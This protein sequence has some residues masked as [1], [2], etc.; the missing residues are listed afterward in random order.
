MSLDS[1]FGAH[2]FGFDWA[3]A[4]WVIKIKML[5]FYNWIYK[6]KMVKREEKARKEASREEK[7]SLLLA[8][9]DKR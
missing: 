1:R 6:K 9:Q 8:A 3:E 7:P 4:I 2:V 5:T